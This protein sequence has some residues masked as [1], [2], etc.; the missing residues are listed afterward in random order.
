[1]ALV[2]IFIMYPAAQSKTWHVSVD[3]AEGSSHTD[4][5]LA[6]QAA[7]ERARALED[8]GHDVVVKQEGADGSWQVI[9]E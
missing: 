5:L 3:G 7:L 1:M 2:R 9:R 4:G 8:M 6:I